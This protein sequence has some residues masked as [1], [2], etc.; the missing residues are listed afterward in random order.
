MFC[1]SCGAQSEEKQQ[2]CRK[3]GVNL[4]IIGKA[5]TLSES[6]ARGDR[7]PLPK[8]KEVMQNLKLDQVSEEV[9]RGLDQMNNAIVHS[10]GTGRLERLQEQKNAA[11]HPHGPWRMQ[12]LSPQE[13]RHHHIAEGT[14]SLFAG[15][16]MMIAFSYFA[17]AIVLK[18]PPE[19]AARIPVD[20][21]L[22]VHNVW[23]LG[24]IPALKGFGELV[25]VVAAGRLRQVEPAAASAPPR[26]LRE[27]AVTGTMDEAPPYE[28]GTVTEGTTELF[29]EIPRRDTAGK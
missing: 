1:P 21:A 17:G 13:R 28:P 12:Q 3:C 7:G 16:A 29:D 15:V 5:L 23:V 18:I 4:G 26:E 20:L 24:M 2:Y 14:K 8:V 11:E 25:G 9:S 6:I 19:F 27:P 22:L 10:M